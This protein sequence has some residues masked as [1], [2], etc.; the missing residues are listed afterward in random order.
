MSRTTW[1]ARLAAW[2]A[3]K[4]PAQ[5]RSLVLG[6]A[7]NGA[8]GGRLTGNWGATTSSA[9]A[10]L[11][12]GL[13][14]L[15][16][17]SRALVRD[18]AYAKRAKTIVVNNVI[19]DGIGLQAQVKRPRGAPEDRLNEAIEEAHLEWS[20]AENCHTG[21]KL[22]FPDLERLLMG[23]V[24]EAGEVFVRKHRARLGRSPV[25]LA[26]EI[27][28][29]ERLADHYSIG[30]A[31]SGN[32]VRLGVEID[33]FQRPVAYWMH[34]GHPGDT[35]LGGGAP[36]QLIR[37]PA[38]QIMHLH[39]VTRWPQTRG[40]PWMHAVMRRLNDMDGYS[41][42]EIIAARGAAA[43]MAFIKTP[44]NTSIPPDGEADGQY[45]VQLEPGIVEQLPPGWDVVMNNP[46]RPNPNMDPF[47]RLMLREVAAGVGVSYESL[48]RDYSQSN[49]SSSRLALLDDRDLWRT[50]QGWFIRTFRAELYR[51]WLEMAVLSGAIPGL[52]V[53]D[54]LANRARY[55]AARFKPRGWSWVDPTKEVEAYKQAV[56][57]GFT[58]VSD[59]ISQTAGGLD[60]E[61]M[62][63]Q[64]EREL[65]LMAAK[66]MQFDTDPAAD[67]APAAA[68]RPPASPPDPAAADGNRA[69][70]ARVV[71]MRTMP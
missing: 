55:E 14:K 25:P 54:Y 26:L 71:P 67:P 17:R 59:V 23:Q 52:G 5:R 10:E 42:A 63:D 16:G 6:R 44:D 29:A 15:R 4:A 50:L 8:G 69:E 61:D 65:E 70:G 27:I 18:G 48:S 45:Q 35:W 49:Y 38:D 57:C 12:S 32:E 28:E 33:A 34:A 60:I 11:V 46:N 1:R 30:R 66:G 40:E 31:P 19:G 58:T 56:R 51:E 64:R 37:V 47:M 68:N 3:P 39:I 9:D 13:Q 41:E 24:F 7:Y 36:D 20:R 21:G 22:A 43:Y 62:L 53:A 2:I